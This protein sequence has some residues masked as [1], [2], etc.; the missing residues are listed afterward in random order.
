MSP[1]TTQVTREVNVRFPECA[2]C[3][4]RL[5]TGT[6]GR[7]FHLRSFWIRAQFSSLRRQAL[8]VPKSEYALEKIMLVVSTQKK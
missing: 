2:Y 4:P 1:F 8:P 6:Q 5:R 7:F 3:Q